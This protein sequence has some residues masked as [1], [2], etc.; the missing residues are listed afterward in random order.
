MI[1][2]SFDRFARYQHVELVRPLLGSD[3]I[4]ILDVGDPYGTLDLL[5]PDDRTVSVDVYA[6]AP[7]AHDRHRHLIGSG[8]DLP[9]PDDSFDLVTTHD[10]LEHVPLERKTEFLA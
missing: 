3:P 1:S 7:P 5:F 4:D 10:T 9:F 2:A 6:E 8:F